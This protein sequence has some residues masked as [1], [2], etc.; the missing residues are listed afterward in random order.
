ML[1]R[2]APSN[3]PPINLSCVCDGV[4]VNSKDGDVSSDDVILEVSLFRSLFCDFCFRFGDA[5]V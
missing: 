2:V 3:Q 1:G 5:L 4:V